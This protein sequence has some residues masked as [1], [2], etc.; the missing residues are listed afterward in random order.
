MGMITGPAGSA[1]AAP[2]TDPVS[3]GGTTLTATTVPAPATLNCSSGIGSTDFSWSA[4][5]GAASYTFH[6]G[7]DGSVAKLVA[8][9]STSVSGLISGGTAWVEANRD[10]GSVTWTSVPSPTRTYTILLL[11]LGSCS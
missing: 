10:F 6:Y 9:T 4:V 8:G 3:V 11:V 7:S 1:S 5:A 2:W